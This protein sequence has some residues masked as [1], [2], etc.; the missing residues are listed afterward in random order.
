MNEC[1][2]GGLGAEK[3]GMPGGN[4]PYMWTIRVS[5]S[6]V[7]A[8]RE[9][10]LRSATAQNAIDDELSTQNDKSYFCSV[11]FSY[12]RSRRAKLPSRRMV[13]SAPFMRSI[14]ASGTLVLQAR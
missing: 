10:K 8:A 1:S 7:S 9:K 13:S 4:A 12:L 14:S 11:Q 5:S 3:G 2:R 6:F